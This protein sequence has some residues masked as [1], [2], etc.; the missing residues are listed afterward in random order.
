M[1]TSKKKPKSRRQKSGGEPKKKKTL[2]VASQDTE[3]DLAE[4][5][6]HKRNNIGPSGQGPHRGREKRNKQAAASGRPD[7]ASVGGKRQSR[8]KNVRGKVKKAA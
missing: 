6:D 3:A 7:V 8:E 1:P 5:Q 4:A 2:H